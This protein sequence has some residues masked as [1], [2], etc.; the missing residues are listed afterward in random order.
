MFERVGALKP[1]S[2]GVRVIHIMLAQ[3]SRLN[4]DF[5]LPP[6]SLHR[7]R[8]LFET[9]RDEIVNTYQQQ[10]PKSKKLLELKSTVISNYD[11][12][13]LF[14]R[15]K[16]APGGIHRQEPGNSRQSRVL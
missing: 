5:D 10:Q 11:V 13:I 15:G 12:S 3:T 16:D 1:R 8:T 2:V 7:G 6:P 14:G 9:T 4:R